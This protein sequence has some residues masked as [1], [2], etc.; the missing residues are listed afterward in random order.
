MTEQRS[1]EWLMARVGKVTA[2]RVGDLMAR[3]RNGWAA[4]R[5][6][7]QIELIVERLSGQPAD[8]YISQAM[9]WGTETE[10]FAKEAYAKKTG[11]QIVECGFIPHP[12]IKMSGASPDGLIGDLGLIEVK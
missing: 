10:P 7:Y 9:A 4:S 3:T 1:P 11:L 5:S 12:K 8:K 2:S 6:T